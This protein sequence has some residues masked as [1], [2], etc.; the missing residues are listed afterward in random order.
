MRLRLAKISLL[1]VVVALTT[2]LVLGQAG[3]LIVPTWRS[4]LREAAARPGHPLFHHGLAPLATF[5]SLFGSTRT[6]YFTNS[7]SMRDASTRDVPLR[8]DKFRVLFMG[9]SMTEGLGV[10]YEEAFAG[11]IGDVLAERNVEVLNGGLISYAGSIYYRKTK[12]YIQDLGLQA[13]AVVV[14]IDISDI[15]DEALCYRMDEDEIVRSLCPRTISFARKAKAFLKANSVYY[16]LY[17]TIKDALSERARQKR[18][19]PI[20]A[21]TN[22]TRGRWTLDDALYEQIGAPG[23]EKNKLYLD[24]LQAFLKERGI[25]LTVAVYPWPD[26][27]LAR[28]LESRQV[29]FWRA[30]AKEQGAGF[31]NLFPVFINDKDPVATITDYFIPY[32]VHFN[33]AGHALVAKAFLEQYRLP[34]RR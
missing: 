16:R 28:D 15:E 12:H 18:L 6:P 17:R 27:I 7:L 3:R 10:R 21:V 19:G 26:Q 30:W 24:K 25:P 33:A 8:S 4:E 14:F 1:I 29:T 9:D 34:P 31:V 20:G 5:E 22:L 23:L 32:D 11:K 13:N 2:D